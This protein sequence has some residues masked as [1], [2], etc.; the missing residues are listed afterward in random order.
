METPVDTGLDVMQPG[1]Q[2]HIVNFTVAEPENYP[3]LSYPVS[4]G[5]NR[6]R[7][8]ETGFDYLLYVPDDFGVDPQKK[9]S[10]ILY[11][12]RSFQILGMMWIVNKFTLRSYSHGYWNRSEDITENRR[13]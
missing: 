13:T 9:W 11:L 2:E 7:S 10:L 8:E 4:T 3:I 12:L 1:V 5:Q 6:Y